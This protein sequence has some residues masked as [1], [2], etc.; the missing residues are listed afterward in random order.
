MAQR[1]SCCLIASSI[2]CAALCNGL[3]PSARAAEFDGAWTNDLN[4]CGKVFAKKENKIVFS[5]NAN[6]YGSGFVIDGNT[7]RGK[8][9]T[10]EIRSMSRKSNK[11]TILASCATDV[12]LSDTRFVL[13]L[14]ADGRLTRSFPGMPEMTMDYFRCDF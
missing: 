6:F 7:I 3:S 12:M 10:C 11:I 2:I 14:G 8:A 5:S 13:A 1:V 9:A 4:M